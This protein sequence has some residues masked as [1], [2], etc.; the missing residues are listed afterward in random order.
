MKK[1]LV[2]VASLLAAFLG[3]VPESTPVALAN[4]M[5]KKTSYAGLWQGELSVGNGMKL[6]LVFH[7]KETQNKYTGVMDSPM[8]GK[9]GTAFDSVTVD[10]SGKITAT[11]A[12]AHASFVGTLDSGK[13]TITGT[14][15]QSG[16]S[17]PLTMAAS[18]GYK[19]PNRPQEPKPPFSYKCE[20]VKVANGDV[21]LAG[22]LTIPEGT[23]PFPAVVLI[24]GSGS[25]DRDETIFS[26]KPFLVLA[27]YLTRRGIAVLR[28]DKRGAGKSTGDAK[29]ATSKDF[30]SDAQK[31]LEFLKTRPEI[32]GNK[33]GMI[34]H[35]EGGVVA[36][37]V[38]AQCDDLHFIVMM[39]G[40]VLPG[41]QILL[42]QV[43]AL[44][45]GQGEKQ[46]EIDH[47]LAIAKETYAIVKSESSDA[48]AISKIKAMRKR[49]GAP[50]HKSAAK[51]AAGDARLEADLKIIVSPWYRFFISYDPRIVLEKV[52]CPVLAINGDRDTQVNAQT[53]LSEIKTAL[54]KGGNKDVTEVVLPGLNHLFQTCKT[55]LPAEYASI[56]ETIA[57]KALQTI[58]DWI[59]S[60]VK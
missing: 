43:Q 54:E 47:S 15:M 8:Q 19:G 24:H 6:P 32:D 46:Q 21:S 60:K 40:S 20:D 36:P 13:K 5:H 31:A 27:D 44:E 42:S 52:H 39:A 57:P 29:A 50:E 23:G 34:G 10:G 56:D 26:H 16:A 41:D 35:S 3:N 53:N 48:E 22:T 14:W 45:A 12:A 51:N 58:G 4:E 11:L 17:L 37:M 18:A 2:S 7:F 1:V 25:H 59:D 28:Y 9:T 55:G 49:L 33:I 30:A 38:A